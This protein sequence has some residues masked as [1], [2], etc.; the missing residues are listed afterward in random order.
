MSK[1][2][3]LEANWLITTLLNFKSQKEYAIN[4]V[5]LVLP[6]YEKAFPKSLCLRKVIQIVKNADTFIDMFTVYT[7]S[8]ATKA[9]EITANEAHLAA[10]IAANEAHLAAEIAAAFVATAA[11]ELASATKI[12]INLAAITPKN[13]KIPTSDIVAK[14]IKATIIASDAAAADNDI[15]VKKQIIKYGLKL[16]KTQ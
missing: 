12:A 5:E 6:I 7:T 9:A 3:F 4:T 11:A 2:K 16:Y 15:K 1:E 13:I 14:Y 8:A 10:E